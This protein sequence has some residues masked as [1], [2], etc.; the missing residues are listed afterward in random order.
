VPLPPVHA[1]RPATPRLIS[2][3][4]SHPVLRHDGATGWH[5]QGYLGPG[6]S[7]R[8]LGTE[9]RT[10]TATYD[11]GDGWTV[12]ETTHQHRAVYEVELGAGIGPK[13]F[14]GLGDSRQ[15]DHWH[16]G[17]TARVYLHHGEVVS[18]RQFDAAVGSEEVHG[19]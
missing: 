17:E 4:I 14:G 9:H 2:R 15:H 11:H 19:E 18:R 12:R 3:T 13:R 6:L 5:L 7:W 10:I 16:D 1:P 8:H